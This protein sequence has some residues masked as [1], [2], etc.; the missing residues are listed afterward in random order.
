MPRHSRA[1]RESLQ[2]RARPWEQRLYCPRGGAA[3]GLFGPGAPQLLSTSSTRLRAPALSNASGCTGSAWT[4]LRITGL[5]RARPWGG[6]SGPAGGPG[7][8]GTCGPGEGRLPVVLPARGMRRVSHSG[9]ADL[10]VAPEVPSR[11]FWRPSAGR[12]ASC[13]APRGRGGRAVGELF[14][15]FPASSEGETGGGR[16][17]GGKSFLG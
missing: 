6:G 13:S 14:L 4:S 3:R 15:N 1:W 11:G 8:R 5:R 10:A 9:T 16:Q 12:R 7:W 2:T 17:S